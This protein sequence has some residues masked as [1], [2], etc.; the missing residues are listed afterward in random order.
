MDSLEDGHPLTILGAGYVGQALLQRYPTAEATH[1]RPAP[2][3]RTYVFDLHEPGTWGN[4]PLAG[5]TIVWTFPAAPL[6]E[7][8]AFHDAHLQDAQSL[9]VLGSTSAYLTP[10][11]AAPPVVTVTEQTPL[12]M[13]Q[14]RV[15]GEEWLRLQGATVLQLAGIFG[16]GREPADWLRRGLIKDG[17]KLVNLI[18]ADDIVAVIEHLLAHPLPGERINLANGETLAW[19]ELAKRFRR[20]GRLPADFKLPESIPG[21]Y[22]KRVANGRLQQLSPGHHFLRP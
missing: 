21:E 22:G 7:V 19:R 5:R 18:H 9:I 1:R 8:Q 2:R 12:D 4:P 16:P 6:S 14:P 10:E 13:T 17:A 20:N 3:T 15:Q 11:T